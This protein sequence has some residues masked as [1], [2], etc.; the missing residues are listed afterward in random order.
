[1]CIS[2]TD[3]A[4]ATA[5]VTQTPAYLVS[6][7]PRSLLARTLTGFSQR[8]NSPMPGRVG[9][10]ALDDCGEPR[11]D[12]EGRLTDSRQSCLTEQSHTQAC[13]HRKSPVGQSGSIGVLHVGNPHTA[14]GRVRFHPP[15]AERMA[16]RSATPGTPRPICLGSSTWRSSPPST[17]ACPF[18]IVRSRM[19]PPWLR[20]SEMK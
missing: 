19:W 12:N 18:T 3:S 1:M 4:R 16:A 7:L 10:A 6:R 15:S 9:P 20:S 11:D 5:L 17:A 2:P 14:R 13:R 8:R